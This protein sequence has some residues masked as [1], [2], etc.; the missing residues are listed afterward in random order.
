MKVSLFQVKVT[1]DEPYEQRLDRVLS[2]VAAEKGQDLIVL[3]ELW[4]HGGFSYD[5]W[6]QGEAL[7][8][9]ILTAVSEAARKAGSYVHAGGIVEKNPSGRPFNTAVIFGPDGNRIAVYRKI[10]LYGFNEGEAVL[11]EPG[12]EIV[13]T[14]LAGVCSGIATCFDVRFPELF[15][16]MVSEGAK[17]FVIPAA[18]PVAR[19]PHWRHLLRARAIE[20]QAFVL[21]CATSGAHAGK[22]MGGYSAIIDPTGEIIAEA[23]PGRDEVIR[24]ELDIAQVDQVRSDFPVLDWRRLGLQ[25]PHPKQ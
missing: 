18:W 7:D 21:G 22:T 8:G 24:A 14:K 10:H 3:P 4:A 1:D 5:G 16:S 19:I 15:R 12:K 17:L 11:F 13:T 2:A 23:S 20:N 6:G 9:P 25:T